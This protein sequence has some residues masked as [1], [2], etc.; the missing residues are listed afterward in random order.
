M[1][2]RYIPAMLA[3]IDIA[4]GTNLLLIL[5]KSRKMFISESNLFAGSNPKKTPPAASVINPNPLKA[6]SNLAFSFLFKVSLYFLY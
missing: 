1:M 3:V 5:S 2:S 4:G 6:E